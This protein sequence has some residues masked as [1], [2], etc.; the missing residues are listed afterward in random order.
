MARTSFYASNSAADELEAAALLAYDLAVFVGGVAL[1]S[2][3]LLFA[4]DVAVP[5]S[6]DTDFGNSV[7]NAITA[8]TSPT[9]LTFKKNGVAFGTLTFTGTTGVFSSTE[10]SF[11]RY[12]LLSLHAPAIADATLAGLT[13]TLTAE[14][15]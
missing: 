4:H 10:T 2:S 13:L 9:I 6:F 5:I 15:V 14:R 12:D 3:E 8:A 1:S 7:A 11:A